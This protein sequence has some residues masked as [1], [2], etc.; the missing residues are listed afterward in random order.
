MTTFTSTELREAEEQLFEQAQ[1][2]AA[3]LCQT[4]GEANI[5]P[6]VAGLACEMISTTISERAQKSYE[7]QGFSSAEE[8]LESLDR[9]LSKL[10]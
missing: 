6:A 8:A 1:S 3:Q 9:K 10:H 7:E 2:L 5:H 4:F